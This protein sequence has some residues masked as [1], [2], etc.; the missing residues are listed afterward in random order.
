MP[1]LPVTRLAPSPTGRLHLGNVWAF[2]ITWLAARS[3]SGKIYLRMDDIDP[4]RSKKEY[5][6][7]ILRDLEWLGLD[8]DAWQGKDIIVQS[9]RAE[10][11]KAALARLEGEG[12]LYPCFCSRKEIR[13]LAGAPHAGEEEYAYTGKC[14]R[15]NA[16]EVAAYIAKGK[17]HTLRFRTSESE[18]H[19]RDLIQ[20]DQV[21]TKRSWGGDFGVRRSDGVWAYQLAS[22]VDDCEMGVNLVVRGCDLLSST[23]RQIMLT[24]ALG[25]AAP[26]HAHLPLLENS[27]GERLAKR[28]ESISVACLR[29]NGI[30]PGE[31]IGRLARLGRLREDDSPV[32]ARELLPS[33]DIGRIPANNIR[34]DSKFG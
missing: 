19:F 1:P 34:V 15:L 9:E 6:T 22:T 23:P 29:E 12:L 32:S 13:S 7:A 17:N 14:S 31:I 25:F 10:A 5:A 26:C 27:D 24:D 18:I 8:W 28:H 2:L 30:K 16:Q 3:S 20:G 21:F 33:F 4:L 11:Y